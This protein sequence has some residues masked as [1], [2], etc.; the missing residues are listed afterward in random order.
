[1]I[2]PR[3]LAQRIAGTRLASLPTAV[4]AA[5]RPLFPGMTVRTHPG[6]IDV[7]DVAA[8]DIFNPPMIA[9]SVINASGPV[10]VAGQFDLVVECA[11]YVITEE[12]AIDSRSTPRDQVALAVCQGL[13]EIL[14]DMDAPRWGLDSITSPTDMRAQPLFTAISYEKG[15]CFYAV[16]WRQTLFAEGHPMDPPMATVRLETIQDGQAVQLWPSEEDGA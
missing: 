13:L 6:R 9:V 7:A 11:A 3:T 2:E 12:M 8:G 4:V 1:M 14:A 16:T 10:Q 15:F 5:L